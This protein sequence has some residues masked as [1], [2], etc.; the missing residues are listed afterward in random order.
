MVVMKKDG[1]TRVVNSFEAVR[2]KEAGYVEAAK[3]KKA[4]NGGAPDEKPK[5]EKKAKVETE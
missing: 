2:L 1:I 4:E 3:P 5:K